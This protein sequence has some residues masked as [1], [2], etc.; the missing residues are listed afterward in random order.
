M[1]G[2]FEKKLLVFLRGRSF[3]WAV[4]PTIMFLLSRLVTE[5]YFGTPPNMIALHQYEGR[6]RPVIGQIHDRFNSAQ[7]LVREADCPPFSF[8][9]SRHLINAS[10]PRPHQEELVAQVSQRVA[11]SD[12]LPRVADSDLLVNLGR[13]TADANTNDFLTR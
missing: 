10:R 13:R 7:A 5:H 6:L 1:I 11:D 9:N 8:E 12:L 4:D 2:L 3:A